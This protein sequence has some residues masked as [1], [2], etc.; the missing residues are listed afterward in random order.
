MLADRAIN[1]HPFHDRFYDG[2]FNQT[3]DGPRGPTV[4]TLPLFSLA[5]RQFEP[6]LEKDLKPITA[7]E[8]ELRMHMKKHTCKSNYR[9]G[10]KNQGLSNGDSRETCYSGSAP[11]NLKSVRTKTSKWL[12]FLAANHVS[13]VQKL[14][15]CGTTK[16]FSF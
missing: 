4:V 2:G 9:L 8:Q 5:K 3:I 1:N 11:G 14:F 13:A 15:G 12:V 16:L 7:T 6:V 10:E